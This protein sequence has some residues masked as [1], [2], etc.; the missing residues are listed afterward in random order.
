MMQSL[1]DR[2]IIYAA[3]HR[4]I[5]KWKKRFFA[6]LYGCNSIAILARIK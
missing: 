1:N 5:A 4:H 6:L 2:I 3:E